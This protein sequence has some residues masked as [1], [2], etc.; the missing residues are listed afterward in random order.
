MYRNSTSHEEDDDAFDGNSES[1]ERTPKAASLIRSRSPML[2]M[3]VRKPSF[4]DELLSEIYDRFG[5]GL[6]SKA[7]IDSSQRASASGSQVRHPRDC[8]K[9][10][11]LIYLRQSPILM[12]LLLMISSFL[13][14]LRL[15]HRIL[16]HLGT[17]GPSV[18]PRPGVLQ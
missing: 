4:V 6:N 11:K 18:L 5:N 7:G 2:G 3:T 10:T 15:P 13:K 16:Y 14:G 12:I 9:K 17:R 1:G 8:V